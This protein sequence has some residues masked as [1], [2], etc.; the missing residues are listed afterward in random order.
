MAAAGFRSRCLQRD[1]ALV[2]VAGSRSLDRSGV[3]LSLFVAGVRFGT[4]SRCSQPSRLNEFVADP[5][6]CSS[7][8]IGIMSDLLDFLNVVWNPAGC[9]PEV[10]EKAINDTALAISQKVSAGTW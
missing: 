3:P 10:A 4:R 8:S 5:L 6:G 9:P 2:V 1:A 7:T